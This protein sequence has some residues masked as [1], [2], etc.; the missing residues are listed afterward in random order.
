MS[1]GYGQYIESLLFLNRKE[2]LELWGEFLLR[3]ESVTEVD[4]SDSAVGV[5]CHSECLDVVAP[6]GPP[7]E[8]TKV[9]LDLVPALV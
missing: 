4:S 3:V 8:V 7:G 1:R 6:V 9:E 5:D 2:E